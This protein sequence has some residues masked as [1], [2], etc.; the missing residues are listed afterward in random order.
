M[1]AVES[2]G[3]R[4]SGSGSGDADGGGVGPSRPVRWNTSAS[5]AT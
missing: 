5:W 4:W 2:G 1:Q 3:M